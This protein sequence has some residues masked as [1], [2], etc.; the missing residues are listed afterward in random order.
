MRS[1]SAVAG[2]YGGFSSSCHSARSVS[3]ARSA[4]S[5]S[6][7][8]SETRTSRSG[9]Y[10]GAERAR[11]SATAAI[12]WR[13]AQRSAAIVEAAERQSVIVS[14]SS[15]PDPVIAT[16]TR[17]CCV[18]SSLRRVAPDVP[19]WHS[20]AARLVARATTVSRAGLADIGASEF[21][22]LRLLRRKFVRSEACSP[23]CREESSM[24][25]IHRLR[26]SYGCFPRGVRGRIECPRGCRNDGVARWG[27]RSLDASAPPVVQ[28]AGN[29]KVTIVGAC[30]GFTLPAGATACHTNADCKK[31]APSFERC[32]APGDNIG[33]G[34]ESPP[35]CTDDT[36]GAGNACVANKATGCCSAKKV[37]QP[38]CTATSCLPG[39][40]CGTKGACEAIRCDAGFSC[41]A[42]MICQP[43]SQSADPHG[44]R[45]KDCTEGSACRPD[46][47]CATQATG[48]VCMRKACVLDTDC[49]CGACM[50]GRCA[51]GPGQCIR[52]PLDPTAWKAALHVQRHRARLVRGR[53]K[54]RPHFPPRAQ[55]PLVHTGANAWH[56]QSIESPF[57]R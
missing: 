43:D 3:C 40:S 26:F 56:G 55:V 42:G 49:S 18:G 39:E 17:S 20:Q 9:T 36:C 51:D 54:E 52:H 21:V 7:K 1:A 29:G 5:L 38:A 31:D 15:T 34:C 22:K 45:A 53:P 50:G 24:Q 28:D 2:R 37:C 14:R 4:G 10:G 13:A 30:P 23:P 32:Y 11:W 48:H 41:A 12:P 46:E 6:S 27:H 33:C 47:I 25:E 57:E 35:D 8:V 19:S 16:V 44:C